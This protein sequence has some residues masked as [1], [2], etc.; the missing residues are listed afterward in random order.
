[1][2]KTIPC[3]PFDNFLNGINALLRDMIKTIVLKSVP[4]TYN[5][6]VLKGKINP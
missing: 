6:L 3:I 5:I 1:M 4:Y 2:K